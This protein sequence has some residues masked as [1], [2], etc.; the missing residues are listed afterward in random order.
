MPGSKAQANP[1]RL[2]EALNRE[3]AK[4]KHVRLTEEV[5]T[6]K[7]N[8]LGP[9][10]DMDGLRTQVQPQP[11]LSSKC[12]LEPGLSN[13]LF[14]PTVMQPILCIPSTCAARVLHDM[15]AIETLLQLCSAQGL[16]T[17]HVY[18]PRALWCSRAQVLGYGAQSPLGSDCPCSRDVNEGV[19]H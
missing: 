17:H 13:L 11:Q 15:I 18:S 7:P 6:C 19:F 12:R 9:S 2:D 3:L 10:S 14:K 1:R 5:A 4:Q 8:E 16:R